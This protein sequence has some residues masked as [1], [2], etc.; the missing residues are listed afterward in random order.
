MFKVCCE[1][2][3]N[4]KSFGHPSY[5]VFVE[6]WDALNYGGGL[7]ID[8]S[9]NTQ[10]KIFSI[11]KFLESKGY[12]VT[13]EISKNLV[14]VLPNYIKWFYNEEFNSVCWCC[15]PPFPVDKYS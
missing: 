8:Q 10:K 5:I 2:V 7:V 11:V 1:C 12:L 9:D 3:S 14:G 13:T 4:V 6:V 15:Q